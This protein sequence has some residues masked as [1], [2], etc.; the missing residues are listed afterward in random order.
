L[1]PYVLMVTHTLVRDPSRCRG[2]VQAV[3]TLHGRYRPP[4]TAE[5]GVYVDY[6]L[7]ATPFAVGS[8]T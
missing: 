6:P 7:Q 8:E 4:G 5:K 2:A 1:S 3:V